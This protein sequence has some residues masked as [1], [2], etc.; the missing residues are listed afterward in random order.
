MLDEEGVPT[1]VKKTKIAP[2]ESRMG[3]VTEEERQAEIA[4]NPLAEK[5]RDMIDRDSA[6]EFIMRHLSLIREE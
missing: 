6:Y 5:Y 2:P 1:I 3:V 4:A